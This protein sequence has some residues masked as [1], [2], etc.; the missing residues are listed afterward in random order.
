[1]IFLWTAILSIGTI[2]AAVL[3]GDAF[4]RGMIERAAIRRKAGSD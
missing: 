4:T 1:L 2:P 3:P